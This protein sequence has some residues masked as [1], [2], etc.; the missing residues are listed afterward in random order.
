MDDIAAAASLWGRRLAFVAA[1]LFAVASAHADDPTPQ[2][3]H[4]AGLLTLPEPCT[5]SREDLLQAAPDENVWVSPLGEGTWLAIALCEHHAYQSTEVALRIEERD[6]AL[7]STLLAFP[8]WREG[9]ETP[10]AYIAY[11]PWLIGVAGDVTDGRISLF[12][13]GRGV[14]D[15]GEQVTYDLTGP[16]VR[17]EEY[18]AKFAC[19]G[20]WVAPDAW[21]LVPQQVLDDYA[22]AVTD[23]RGAA[24]LSAAMLRWPR[25]DWMGHAIVRGDLDADGVEEQWIGGYSRNW[26]TERTS[27]HLVREQGGT[28][29]SWDLPVADDTQVALCQPAAALVFEDTGALAI[30]DGLC[31]RLRVGWDAA[32]DTIIV[33]RN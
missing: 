9:E 26:D 15:C 12:Y 31:D 17:I 27:Y 19:D 24:L 7:T 25:V 11:H 10:W 6:G 22:P 23:G 8:S 33:E 30:D 4:A 29:R 28:L 2:S 1:A 18:R 20:D 14:G 13:K 5:V 3:L 16:V 32:A 21:P